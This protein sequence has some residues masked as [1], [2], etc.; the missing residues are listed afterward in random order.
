MVSLTVRQP[1]QSPQKRAYIRYIKADNTARKYSSIISQTAI[2]T[3][4][5][6]SANFQKNKVTTKLVSKLDLPDAIIGQP[7]QANS[8]N[9]D[10]GM[11]Q[12]LVSSLNRIIRLSVW[13]L[14]FRPSSVVLDSL[15]NFARAALATFN[16]YYLA[17]N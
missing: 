2:A 12:S 9:G 8:L 3:L 6:K 15:A 10:S 5:N 17:C 13:L 14:R 7:I 11:L 1:G 16:W 4:A